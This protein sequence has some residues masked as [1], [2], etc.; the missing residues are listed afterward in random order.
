MMK[1]ILIVDDEKRVRDLV[2]ATLE[3]Q[4]EDLK[5]YEA[6]D[7]KEAV[8][9]AREIAP[10]LIILDVMMPGASGYQVCKEIRKIPDI[11]DTIVLFLT[12]R[13]GELSE[14]TVELSGGD[15]IMIKP[16]NPIELRLKVRKMLG[17]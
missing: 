5:I 2:K 4:S 14:K 3:V 10:D 15:D 12:A 17:I 9:K 11:K 8:V 13:G 6:K 16:F 1:K 7:G